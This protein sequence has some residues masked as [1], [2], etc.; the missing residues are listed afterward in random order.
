MVPATSALGALSG[1]VQPESRNNWRPEAL[2]VALP[3]WRA[4]P[5][6]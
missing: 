2:S 6:M 1:Q 5:I 4:P 3:D